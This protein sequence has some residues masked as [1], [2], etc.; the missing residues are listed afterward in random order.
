MPQYSQYFSM[1]GGRSNCATVCGNDVRLRRV[2]QVLVKDLK[3]RRRTAMSLFK[4]QIPSLILPKS[5]DSDQLEKE[6]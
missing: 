6:L 2:N 4:G 1:Y 3:E 5:C